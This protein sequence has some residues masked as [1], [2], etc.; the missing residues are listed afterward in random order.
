MTDVTA[1][2]GILGGVVMVWATP[3]IMARPHV[4]TAVFAVVL[5]VVSVELAHRLFGFVV[6][7]P[8][9]RGAEPAIAVALVALGISGIWHRIVEYRKR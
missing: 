1:E 7:L 3:A 2:V 5:T 6:A 4:A 9:P 8:L